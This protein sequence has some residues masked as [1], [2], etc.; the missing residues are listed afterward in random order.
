MTITAPIIRALEQ[1]SRRQPIAP[2][3]EQ[4]LVED[5]LVELNGTAVLTTTGRAILQAYRIGRRRWGAA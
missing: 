1:V 3:L 2:A 4:R 5:Q